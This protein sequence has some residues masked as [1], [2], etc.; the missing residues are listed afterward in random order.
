M[1]VDR[2]V[3]VFL[4][5]I[6]FELPCSE[7]RGQKSEVR[8]YESISSLERGIKWGFAFSY[9]PI[10]SDPTNPTKPL[11]T[12]WL[13]FQCCHDGIYSPTVV[14]STKNSRALHATKKYKSF[15][16]KG[17]D[18]SPPVFS[19]SIEFKRTVRSLLKLLLSGKS[20]PGLSPW[21]FCTLPIDIYVSQ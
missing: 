4:M 10:R 12:L 2:S 21:R 18:I 16:A 9:L 19:A 8:G 13:I 11:L 3:I 15:L 7:L 17:R 14:W 5:S 6:G 20:R 1:L